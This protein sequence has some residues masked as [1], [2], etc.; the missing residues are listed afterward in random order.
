MLGY[1]VSD[2]NDAAIKLQILKCGRFMHIFKWAALKNYKVGTVLIGSDCQIVMCLSQSER[3][4]Q[5]ILSK[6][7]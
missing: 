1:N 7:L 5:T 2:F 4:R 3:L 6:H